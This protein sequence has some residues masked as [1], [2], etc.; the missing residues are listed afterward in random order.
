[1][2]ENSYTLGLL[3]ASC[4]ALLAAVVL[5]TMEITEYGKGAPAPAARVVAPPSPASPAP[6]VE[7]K[8]GAA[9]SGEA[10]GG[11]EAPAEKAV[12]EGEAPPA[13]AIEGGEAPAKGAEQGGG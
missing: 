13:K 5:T 8:K 4:V 10:A 3:V 1:V 11:A 9:P 12:R 6:A 7:E 2:G